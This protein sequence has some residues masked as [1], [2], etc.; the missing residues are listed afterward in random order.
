MSWGTVICSICHRE[1]HQTGPLDQLTKRHGWQH[2]E[3][4]SAMCDGAQ[5]VYPK[6][7]SEVQGKWCGAD[8]GVASIDI[9]GNPIHG[10]WKPQKRAGQ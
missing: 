8:G 5:A 4:K 9:P 2:C 10:M 1:V 6:S 7:V 3:D